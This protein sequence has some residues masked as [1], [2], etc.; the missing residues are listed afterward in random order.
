MAWKNLAQTDLTDLLIHPHEA[1]EELDGLNELINWTRIEAKLSGS[2][3]FPRQ[4]LLFRKLM[5]S[6]SRLHFLQ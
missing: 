3:I 4:I 5:F 1:L 2:P 6:A